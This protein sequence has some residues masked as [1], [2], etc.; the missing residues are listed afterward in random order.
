[1]SRRPEIGNVQL[2]PNRPLRETDRNG[3]VLKFYCPIHSKRIRRNC[4][5]RDRRE[6]RRIL[7]ECRKR[8]LNG[9]YLESDGAIT[10]AHELITTNVRHHIAVVTKD[11][12][13]D[14]TWE[15]CFA[16]YYE[17]RKSRVRGKSLTDAVSRLRMAECILEGRREEAGLPEGGSIREFTSLESMEYLQDRLLAGDEG[18]Y[19]YRAPITVNTMMGAVMSFV[20]YCDKHAWIDKAPPL[21]KL[22]V[23]DVMKGRPITDE[24]LDRMLEMTPEVVG[25]RSAASWKYVLQILWE[26]AFRVADV[27][28][29]SWND[30][31]RI[32]PIWPSRHGQHPTLAIPSSQKNK[33]VQEIPMLP[34]LHELLK[35]TPEIERRGWVVNPLPVDYQIRAKAD[36]FKPTSD[37]MNGLANEYNNR[38]IAS[39]CGVTDTTVRK[40]LKNAGIQRDAKFD[41]YH[42]NIDENTIA[43]VRERA[44][45]LLSHPARR[46]ERRLTK[47]RVSRII[48]LIGE[49]AKIVVQEA[50]EQ[51]G[52]RIKYASAHDLR[53]GCAQRLINAGVSAE[54]L[55]VVLR[56]KDFN[57][58][59]RFYGATRAAQ[60]AATE[61]HEKLVAESK[62]GGTVAGVKETPQL[63]NEE[64]RKLKTLLN[65]I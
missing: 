28:Q 45:R 22:D 40:W 42:G 48:S 51:T 16:R 27:M 59:E 17:H 30:E 24:E 61:I 52:R 19:D 60:S 23:D 55:K 5:T 36:W 1:M 21:S 54:T 6:A 56:H 32:H 64:V 65:S 49:Q 3:Y 39:A 62:N 31:R 35:Q 47:E 10:E 14:K 63:S 41:R 26:S 25:D 57:T 43:K 13:T 58:T 38:A 15:E 12:G 8:L 18:R 11:D 53:R 44:Q 46:T 20:R 29:F 34:G 37:D 9:K 2:Y 33:K 50:D 7:R 4:G